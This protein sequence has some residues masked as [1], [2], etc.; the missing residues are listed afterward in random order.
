V[1]KLL[2]EG[3]AVWCDIVAVELWNGA[4]GEYER[5]RLA[6]LERGITCLATTPEV[7]QK[8]RALARKTRQAGLT[9][10]TTDLVIVACALVHGTLL[11][12]RDDHFD[13]ILRLGTEGDE[14]R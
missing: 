4:R 2:V 3:R 13:A 8:A 7:W 5:S 14:D 11:E 10:P 6:E 1:R 12:H 9:V